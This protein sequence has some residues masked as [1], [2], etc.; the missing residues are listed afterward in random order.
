MIGLTLE[1][2]KKI[3]FPLLVVLIS[4]LFISQYFNLD[5]FYNI[6]LLF[7]ILLLFTVIGIYILQT[8]REQRVNASVILQSINGYLLLG[9]ISSLIIIIILR[10]YDNA[11]SFPDAY[12][13]TDIG[14]V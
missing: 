7:R 9:V 12:V 10:Y 13:D 5:K 14:L 1:K 3:L 2:G 6:L 11:F 4:L 8:S